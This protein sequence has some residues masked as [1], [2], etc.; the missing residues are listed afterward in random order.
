MSETSYSNPR[1]LLQTP[2]WVVVFGANTGGPQ[3]LAQVLPQFSARFPGAII[4]AQQMRPGFTRVLVHHLQQLCK[5]PVLEPEDGQALL[6]SRIVVAP[7]NARL[8]IANVGSPTAPGY[9]VILEDVSGKPDLMRS[10]V[11]AV[12][13]SAAQV[14][15]PTVVSVLLTGLGSDGRE[16]M[17]AVRNAGGFTIAQDEATSVVHSLPASAIE[18]GIVHEV[19]PLWSIADRIEAIVGGDTDAIAA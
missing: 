12:M 8:T 4:V 11:D 9:C 14:F 15:G 5:M 3:A 13:T 18:A 19:L 17:R 2:K 6:A 10:R 7:S 1:R 16:G